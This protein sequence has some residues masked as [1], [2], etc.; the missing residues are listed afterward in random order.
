MTRPPV[1]F[2]QV[3]G[4]AMTD[5]FAHGKLRRVCPACG[6]IHFADPKVAVVVFIEQGERVLLVRR[7]MDPERGKWA[8]PAGYVD[9]GEH[10]RT[11]AVREVREET[12]LHVGITRLVDVES[13]PGSGGASIVITYAARVI[14]GLARPLDDADAVCWYSADDPLPDIAFDSTRSML[15][16]WMKQVQAAKSAK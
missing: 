1:N 16:N 2:C 5:K 4:H 7:I 15:T 3:C 11:A 9:D 8:L 13:G 12:G 14:D 10:P 6:F